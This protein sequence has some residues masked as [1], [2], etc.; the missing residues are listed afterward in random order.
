[1]AATKTAGDGEFSADE[2]VVEQAGTMF[3]DGAA[4]EAT[5]DETRNKAG[6]TI[7]APTDD[8]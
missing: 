2:A 6:D 4:P 8:D 5:A 3:E 1:M 7:D